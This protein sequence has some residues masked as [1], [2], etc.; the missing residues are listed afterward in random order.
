[1]KTLADAWNWYEATKRNLGRMQRLGRNIGAI[2]PGEKGD[3]GRDDEFRTL[4]ASD[5]V[6]ETATSLKPIDDLAIVVLFS[7]FE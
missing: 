4:E 2:C 3:I 7:V 1:M 5:I 6:K